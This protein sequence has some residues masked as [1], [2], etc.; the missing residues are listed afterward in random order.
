MGR[1]R[2]IQWTFFVIHLKGQ[3]GVEGRVRVAKGALARSVADA[4]L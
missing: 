2:I 4:G 1:G 3:V